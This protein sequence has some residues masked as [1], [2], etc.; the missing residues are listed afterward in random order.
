M[1]KIKKSKSQI[2]KLLITIFFLIVFFLITLDYLNNFYLNHYDKLII[3]FIQENRT[4]FLNNLMLSLTALGQG[5][6]ILTESL[7]A[8]MLLLK[9]KKY[10]YLITLALS[11]AGGQFF[12]IFFKNLLQ[13]QRPE[14]INALTQENTFSLPSGHSFT[15]IVFYG[16]ILYLVYKNLKSTSLKI[17]VA[18]LGILL[19]LAI[20][21]SRIYLGVHWPSDV[22]AGYSLGMAWVVTTITLL[23]IQENRHN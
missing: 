7:I 19:I 14:I 9:L 13:R 16:L 18:V 11:S 3:H 23:K 1:I 10:H 21:F 22:L 8:T 5:K 6:V 17:A 12:V 15:A 4:Q 20:G 2:V